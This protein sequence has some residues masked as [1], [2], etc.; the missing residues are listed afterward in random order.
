MKIEDIKITTDGIKLNIYLSNEDMLKF[1]KD[2]YE[3]YVVVSELMIKLY[4]VMRIYSE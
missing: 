4:N 3:R 2:D 1:K